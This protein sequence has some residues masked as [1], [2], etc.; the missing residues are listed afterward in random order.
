MTDTINYKIID[1]IS[2]IKK[3]EWDLIFGDIPEGYRFYKALEESGL[4]EFSFYYVL[5]YEDEKPV[6]IAPLFITRFD[7]DSVLEETVGS[8]IRRIRRIIP[9]F[10][11]F[12][13]LFC[14]S[15]FGENGMLGIANNRQDNPG[16][17][18]QL[19]N[20]LN[21]FAEKNDV[22][23][24]VF[25]D[26]MEADTQTLDCL[27]EHGFFKT[28][29]FP[30]AIVDLGFD[31]MDAY[32]K[33]LSRGTRKSLRRKLR[34]AYAKAD[35]TV[36][37]VQNVADIVDDIYRLYENTHNAGKT[38]FEKLTKEFFTKI[39]EN[40]GPGCKYFLYH[41]NGR[42]AAFNLCF[43]HRDLLIDKFIGF[44]Y[45][46]AY[47]YSLYFLSWCYNVD[48]CLQNSIHHYQVGQTDYAPK[49]QLGG[50]L[51]PLYAYVKH[52]NPLLN[53]VLKILSKFLSV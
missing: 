38:R 46:I 37:V 40:L 21:M 1:S 53:L 16:I 12:K 7:V 31:S 14:G 24:I 52:T 41:V 19:I 36:M 27:T 49:K 26:F 34:K 4:E 15:P 32:F 39:A 47:D 33:S 18:S 51:V 22:S 44:D 3:Q 43:V 25:K 23:L 35:I 9:K 50:K 30:S 10:L 45:D 5:L 6:L 42:L 48:W 11:V 17:I 29:S 28:D 2:K 13:T 8:S 20:I